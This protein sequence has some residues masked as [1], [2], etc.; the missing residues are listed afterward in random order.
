MSD[1][2][3]SADNRLP[4]VAL[5]GRH[6]FRE[7]VASNLSQRAKGYRAVKSGKGGR[8]EGRGNAKCKMMN[9]AAGALPPPIF[10]ILSRIR[11]G[12][13]PLRSLRP[14]ARNLRAEG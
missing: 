8:W 2:G 12:L 9:Q 3:G 11:P 10:N 5:K 14:C 1:P 4:K 7:E 13:V 6:G